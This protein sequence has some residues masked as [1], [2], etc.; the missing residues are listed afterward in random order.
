MKSFCANEKNVIR[1]LVV[2]AAVPMT[3][4][5]GCFSLAL[6]A[7]AGTDTAIDVNQAMVLQGSAGG[8][9][10]PYSY[11][12]SPA[13]GLSSTSAAQPMFTPPSVGTFIFTLTVT[14]AAG[15][16]VTDSVTVTVTTDNDP[17][18]A[19]AG[20]DQ[21]TAV[22]QPVI[23]N[24]SAT[25]GDEQYGY[26]WSPS[27]NLSGSSVASPAFTP[28]ET[29]TFTFVLTVTDGEGVSSSDSVDVTVVT[30]TT[31]S[32]ATWGS[33]RTDSYNVS[34]VFDQDVDQASAETV[35]NY[36]INGTTTTATT[37]VL[38]ADDR[39]V[40][41]T[42]GGPLSTDAGIDISVGSSILDANGHAVP[43]VTN[44]SPQANSGDTTA[45]SITSRTWAANSA[46]S[47]QVMVLFS[48]V[49][50]ETTAETLS[51]YRVS[52][53][54]TT[55][56]SATLGDDGRTV[57]VLFD[58]VALSTTSKIDI[59]VGDSI[60]D[61]NGNALDAALGQSVSTNSDDTT[62]PSIESI[63]FAAGFTSGGYKIEIIFSEV[64][65]ETDVENL[66]AYSINASNPSS[67]TLE[68]DGQTVTLI[69]SIPLDASDKIDI[70]LNSRI[71]DINGQALSPQS[72]QSIASSVEDASAPSVASAVYTADY[73]GG[74]YEITVTFSE[75]MDE[76]TVEDVDHWRIN[77]TS[78]KPTS[79]PTLA[80]DGKTVTLIFNVPLEVGDKLDVSVGNSIEDINGNTLLTVTGRSISA[81]TDTTAPTISSVTWAANYTTAGYALDVVFSEAMD[82]TTAETLA[83]YQI[84]T[85][86][87]DPATASLGT[88]GQ[89]VRLTFTTLPL[90]TANTLD[91]SLS[92]S[93]TDIN[94]Q[95][96]VEELDETIAANADDITAPEIST[97]PSAVI[98][99][100]GIIQPLN[101]VVIIT[102]DEAMD[103]TTVETVGNYAINNGD[104][105]A[106]TPATAALGNDGKT[107]TL[108]WTTG[109]PTTQPWAI[110]DTM[111]VSIGSS[112]TDINGQAVVAVA[113]Q[114][115]AANAAD[116]AGPATPNIAHIAAAVTITLT[117]NEVLDEATAEAAAYATDKGGVS[118][119]A[120]PAGAVLDED[121]VT[122]ILTFD[123]DPGDGADGQ[124][125]TIPATIKDINGQTIAGA[126][127]TIPN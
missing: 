90:D 122:V 20:P 6:T 107:V 51:A 106:P 18:V 63:R 60:T 124:I 105:P 68:G 54:T 126:T 85:A 9:T 102:F 73:N 50:D 127:P 88:D 91:V 24:G 71:K 108:T 72:N 125:L 19:N 67:A 103:E 44:R 42:F 79:T 98:Y 76:S 114:A 8:G 31:V 22:S 119:V 61:I 109:P 46:T 55:A 38:S 15:A 47:Y 86:G 115:I 78:D 13:T 17:V 96:V 48:E 77:G 121:G 111:D 49:L 1:I 110:T 23:L 93:I 35:T 11:A 10:T 64:L 57:T 40:T 59:S 118:L 41:L 80:A 36:R 4:G 75:A 89:T 123:A 58:N 45:P 12:W 113:G 95:A 32:S 16:V 37:A 39:T 53:T 66:T 30:A 83:N 92:S 100:D 3:A 26:S 5:L 52:G 43:E 7:D 87:D 74:G 94:G 29:G 84:N 70:S 65:S 117:F 116:I 99:G 62:A 97:D 25:G 34:V 112:I 69:Y 27:V 28:T 56:L 120:A 101:Y 2:C 81:A 82:K 21:S 104:A 33:N 14:D